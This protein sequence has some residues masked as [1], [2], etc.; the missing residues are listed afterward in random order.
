MT[1]RGQGN[2]SAFWGGACWELFGHVYR[3]GH[4]MSRPKQRCHWHG[5][6]K[7]SVDN[8]GPKYFLNFKTR[9][10][11]LVAQLQNAKIWKLEIVGSWKVLL[12][13]VTLL[14]ISVFPLCKINSTTLFLLIISFRHVLIRYCIHFFIF[15]I[16]SL[17]M[18]Y[19]RPFGRWHP[20]GNLRL[21]RWKGFEKLWKSLHWMEMSY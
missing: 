1:R 13:P 11:S 19:L 9:T 4:D 2:D 18:D 6:C 15:C 14:I 21:L 17:K 8:G 7:F 16:I 10:T 3:V 5:N 20:I 12:Y